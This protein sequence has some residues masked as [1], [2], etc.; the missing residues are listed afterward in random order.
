MAKK[1][2]INGHA[3]AYSSQ[4]LVEAHLAAA[5]PVMARVLKS[6]KNSRAFLVKAGIATK[7]GRLAKPYR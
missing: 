7:S 4:E 6:K 3:K 2:N 5:K 1:Q